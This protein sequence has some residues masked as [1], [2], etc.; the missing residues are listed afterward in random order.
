MTW[1]LAALTLATAI[2]IDLFLGEPKGKLLKIHPVTFT[3]QLCKF[4]SK[5][6][7]TKTHG[8]FSFCF[9]VLPCVLTYSTAHH[10]S[11]TLLPL[12][13]SLLF[14]SL[15]LKTT[16]S[17]NLLHRIVKNVHRALQNNQINEAREELQNIVRRNT[18]KLNKEEMVSAT[19][20]SLFESLVD[21]YTSPLF[22]YV[23]LGVPGALFQRATNTMDSLIGYR[24]PN[25]KNEGYFSAKLDTTLNYIPARLT[26]LLIVLAAT[27]T[28]LNWRK[29]LKT[30]LHDHKKTPSLNAGWP[31]AAAAGALEIELLKKDYYRLGSPLKKLS[32]KRITEALKLYKATLLIA[33]TLYFLA[34]YLLDLLF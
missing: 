33:T 20:E 34:I 13:I 12:P 28:K 9:S 8:L 25:Y 31:M 32:Q 30:M 26:A 2:L 7:S 22:Y 18:K 19:I 5:P 23:F 29:S 10:L 4:F 15:I 27:I 17:I 1:L 6:Y 24:T 11:T 16:F 14:S 21:G 3:A